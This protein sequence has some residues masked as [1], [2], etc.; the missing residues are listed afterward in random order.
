[1]KSW[2]KGRNYRRVKDESGRIVRYIITIDGADIEVT[3][4]VFLAYSQAER[5][6]RYLEERD[7]ERGLLHLSALAQDRESAVP[8]ETTISAEE[9]MLRHISLLELQNCLA[10]LTKDDRDLIV[11]RYW[12]CRSQQEL[13]QEMGISQQ[14]VSYKERRIL[15]AM[16]KFLKKF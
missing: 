2:Q 3:E 10:A 5:R 12:H 14:A 15:E 4:D 11:Q 13:A 9:H 8:D 1:M 7:Q 6:E 16:K